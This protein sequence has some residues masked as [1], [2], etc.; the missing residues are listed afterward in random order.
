MANAETADSYKAWHPAATQHSLDECITHWLAS[1][2]LEQFQEAQPEITAAVF[3][4]CENAIKR[5]WGE[6][7]DAA[8]LYTI[9][10]T[11][12]SIYQTALAEPLSNESR[13]QFNPAILRIKTLIE[14]NWLRFEAQ[15]NLPLPDMTTA[16]IFNQQLKT[17]WSEHRSAAHP[18]YDYLANQATIN[19]LRYFFKS[20]SAL[21]LVFFDL[22]AM[23]MIGSRQ[24]VRG[25]LSRNMWDESG[26]GSDS[27]THTTLYRD[28]L[29]RNAIEAASDDYAHLLTWQG[30]AGYNLFLLSGLNR[31]HYYKLIGALAMTEL[32]DP[33]Q[34][35]KLVFAGKRLGLTDRDLH[36]YAEHISVDV[37]HAD[38][39]L[40]NVILPVVKKT[41]E[42]MR[43]IW[44]GANL[45][46]NTVNDYYDHLLARLKTLA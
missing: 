45:R 23:A 27:H 3:A 38:G 15:R 39:W 1:E 16:D 43:E 29:E 42:A 40:N 6:E 25:E 20:D 31:Q 33:S 7:R 28:L 9:Q 13:N 14:Q 8:S 35:E 32:L 46:L 19:Q 10:K 4:L 11:L 26:M 24:E 12:F 30:L 22:I 17:L 5:A 2:R 41:P 18:L 34:Y 36:Y 37:V 21:N 44:L